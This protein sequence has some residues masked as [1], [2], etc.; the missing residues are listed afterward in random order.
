MQTMELTNTVTPAAAK[1]ASGKMQR[2]LDALAAALPPETAF[3]FDY[4]GQTQRIGQGAVKFRVGVKNSQA[5]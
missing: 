2:I 3:E 4:A 5:V 1:A